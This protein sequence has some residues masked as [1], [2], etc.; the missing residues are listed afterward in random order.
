MAGMDRRRLFLVVLTAWLLVA[1]LI[2]AAMVP[3]PTWI[4]G[5]YDNG[6]NDEVAILWE[7]TTGIVE[8]VVVPFTQVG[9]ALPRVVA[10]V[11]LVSR[12]LPHSTSRAPP[13]A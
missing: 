3:D 11:Q 10:P 6:D 2:G 1:P 12:P 13:L 7:R 9:V 4:G 5:V 8:I